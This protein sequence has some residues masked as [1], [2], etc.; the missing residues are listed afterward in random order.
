MTLFVIHLIVVTYFLSVVFRWVKETISLEIW[1]SAK[2]LLYLYPGL[3]LH[4]TV[5][6]TDTISADLLMLSFALGLR[7]H[8]LGAGVALGCCT[9]MRQAYLPLTFLFAGG[10]MIDGL[11]KGK[12][13]RRSAA[14]LV[15]GLMISMGVPLGTCALRFHTVCLADQTVVTNALE[16]SVAAGLLTA[17][18]RWS[19][20]VPASADGGTARVPGVPDE[21]LI[22]NFGAT[23]QVPSLSCLAT[24]AHLLPFL[25]FKKAVA[26]HDNYYAQPYVAD[27]TPAWYRHVSRLFGCISFVGFFGCLLLAWLLRKGT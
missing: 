18:V 13:L 16:G 14:P 19:R 15:L 3:V 25:A 8:W 1:P 24:R 27:V 7:G 22:R 20:V 10:A 26:L 17:R 12:M 5:L 23:C 9:W 4:T 11:L 6:L 21:F 2:L